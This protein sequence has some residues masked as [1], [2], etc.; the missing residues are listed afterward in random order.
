MADPLHQDVREEPLRFREALKL[1]YELRGHVLPLLPA[2]AGI[3]AL[4]LLQADL[5]L[6]AASLSRLLLDSFIPGTEADSTGGAEMLTRWLVSQ[7]HQHRSVGALVAGVVLTVLLAEG[8]GLLVEWARF[9]VAQ[10]FRQRLQS[11]LLHA[12]MRD[13]GVSRMKRDLGTLDVTFRQDVGGIGMFLIFGLLGFVEKLIKLGLY[14][15][16]LWRIGGGQ[17]WL[18]VGLLV[19]AAMVLKAGIM[20]LFLGAERRSAEKSNQSMMAAHRSAFAFF[21][22]MSRLVLLRGEAEPARQLLESTRQAAVANRRFNALTNIHGSVAHLLGSLSLPVVALVMSNLRVTPG[23][24]VQIAAIYQAI[25]DCVGGLLAFP[26]QFLQYGPSLRRVTQALRVPPVPPRPAELD[27]LASSSALEVA[28]EGIDYGYESQRPLLAN[29][30]LTIPAGSLVCLAG[31]SGSGKTTVARLLIGELIPKSG[32]IALGGCPVQQWPLWW[33]RELIAFLPEKV[34]FLPCSL[35]DNIRFGRSGLSDDPLRQIARSCGL[36][37][38]LTEYGDQ[39]LI[40]PD[41]Q[42]SA[43]QQRRVGVARLLAGDTKVW[44][45]DEPLANLDKR[46]MG[47]VAEAIR[48][49]ARGRTTIVITHDPEFFDADTIFFLHHGRVAAQGSHHDLLRTCPEYA[50]VYAS[51]QSTKPSPASHETAPDF[52]PTAASKSIKP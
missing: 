27:S 42:L 11:E 10:S 49:A 24:I 26:S 35:L 30:T 3:M 31:G 23:S 39:S 14:S 19:P 9:G 45:L 38:V 40:A 17:G 13:T 22:S 20:G 21:G 41:E 32:R 5:I 15:V 51:R 33:R 16:A 50:A 25:L 47:G 43:G 8:C 2:A 48:Q 12:F 6:A 1:G 18:L 52:I 36:A 7:F 46:L 34:G 29:L 28:L 44:V 4:A 37:D